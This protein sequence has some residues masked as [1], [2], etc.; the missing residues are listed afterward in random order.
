MSELW[1]DR[2]VVGEARMDQVHHDFS[3]ILDEALGADDGYLGEVLAKIQTHVQEHFA[4]ED[5][6]MREGGY[7]SAQCHLDE[8]Q[9]VLD[10]ILQVR[11]LVARGNTS[12][13]RRLVRELVRWFPEHTIAMDK[14]LADWS[15]K[16]RLGGMKVQ[17]MSRPGRVPS[18]A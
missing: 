3:R 13:G 18:A 2:L 11:D 15:E 14:G 4:Q 9:A 12:V 6:M 8:H 5:A 7:A 1:S 17:F 16:R 10:S